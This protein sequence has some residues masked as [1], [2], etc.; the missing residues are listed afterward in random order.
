MKRYFFL[1]GINGKPG[2][3]PS[4]FNREVIRVPSITGVLIT[5]M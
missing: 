5:K 2:L 4:R 3:T 1:G